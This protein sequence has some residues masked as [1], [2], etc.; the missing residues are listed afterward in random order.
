MWFKNGG[1]LIAQSMGSKV[2]GLLVLLLAVFFGVSAC[3]VI[4]FAIF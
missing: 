3:V 4:Y 2:F 1:R